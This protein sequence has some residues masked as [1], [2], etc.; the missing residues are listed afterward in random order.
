[1]RFLKDHP[2]FQELLKKLSLSP[3]KAG[4]LSPKRQETLYTAAFAFYEEGAYLKAER[5]FFSL[6]LS[7]P[8]Q[9]PYW[10]GLAS[11]RQMQKKY[12]EALYAWA[13][14]NLLDESMPLPHFHAA[15]CL[16]SLGKREDALLALA[17][18]RS[19]FLG[20]THPVQPHL[21]AEMDIW[22][23]RI[24]LLENFCKT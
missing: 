2:Q 18:A 16:V 17:L 15:E 24:E 22:I 3:K 5:L 6:L 19:R 7:N 23:S 20:Q 9:L 1:M 12:E 8:W 11:A 4:S 14:V 10:E 21:D 13:I